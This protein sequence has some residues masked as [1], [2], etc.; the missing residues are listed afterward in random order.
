MLYTMSLTSRT[1]AGAG[2]DV[3]YEEPANPFDKLLNLDNFVYTPH[4]AGWTLEATN[5]TTDIILKNINL[6][7]QGR[8]PLTVIN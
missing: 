4:I 8:K 6:L 7:F 1:I 2:F 3:F 5:T